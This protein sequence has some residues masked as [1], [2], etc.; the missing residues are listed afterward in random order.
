MKTINCYTVSGSKSSL[1]LPNLLKEKV[2]FGLLAQAWRVYEW[3]RHKELSKVKTRGEVSLSTAKI[4]R[5]KGT[6]RARHGSRS[7][8]IFVGGGVAHGPKG[9]RRILS[10]SK[11]M[12]KK[13]LLH[14]L[15][16]KAD[17]NQIFVVS[18]LSKI[19]KTKDAERL[20]EIIKSK[21]NIKNRSSFCLVIKRENSGLE[22]AF[23]NLENFK[24]L[25]LENLNAMDVL[26]SDYLIF[27]KGAFAVLSGK[28]KSLDKKE[29]EKEKVEIEDKKKNLYKI[30]KKK[31][32]KSSKLKNKSALKR[33]SRKRSSK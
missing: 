31:V 13:A 29:K 18:G 24:V 11:K 7:A 14:S 17:K 28:E 27:E 5:Q 4:W 22:R 20:V 12:A 25:F 16:Y 8:P 9:V 15:S 3:R 30:G 10:V 23:R 32:I 1:E 33:V 19:F 2:N 21:E 26:S 6:G